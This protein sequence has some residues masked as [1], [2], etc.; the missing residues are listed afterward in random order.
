MQNSCNNSWVAFPVPNPRARLR[1]FCFPYAGGGTAIYRSWITQLPSDIEVC[2][3]RLP[4]R[5]DKLREPPYTRLF[6]LVQMLFNVLKPYMD[7]P[8]AFF[9]HSMGALIG[10]E[11]ARE[12]RRQNCVEPV[13]FFVSG[14]RAPHLPDSD[15][16]IH[17]LPEAEFIEELKSLNGTPDAI[18]Q[19]PELM[20]LFLPVLRADFSILETY[21]YTTELPLN[22]SITTF[23][24]SRDHKANQK[25][26]SA[27]REQTSR[28]FMQNMFPGDHFFFQSMRTLFLDTMS[29]NLTNLLIRL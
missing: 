4:G 18:L 14:R 8:F 2:P 15:S 19:D 21:I 12:L 29:Q 11:L 28:N 3:V 23:G 10:F 17:N 26:L 1:L 27:W 7:V 9:G 16:P 20:K 25:D 6:P 24:G 22:C 13:H 5:E